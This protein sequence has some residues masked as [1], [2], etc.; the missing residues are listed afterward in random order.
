MNQPRSTAVVQAGNGTEQSGYGGGVAH[1]VAALVAGEMDRAEVLG[2]EIRRGVRA[3]SPAARVDPRPG[4]LH[5]GPASTHQ[6][7]GLPQNGPADAQ[8]VS[9]RTTAAEARIETARLIQ[10]MLADVE[11]TAGWFVCQRCG[12]EFWSRWSL[13]RYCNDG[14]KTEARRDTWRKS[15]AKTRARQANTRTLT[16]ESGASIEVEQLTTSADLWM[17]ANSGAFERLDETRQAE[18]VEWAGGGAR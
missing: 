16:T 12:S 9:E 10:R 14:C 18:V 2:A 6:Q 11:S 17:D 7:H 3:P 4:Y 5:Q 15:Q 1:D 8:N 13:A